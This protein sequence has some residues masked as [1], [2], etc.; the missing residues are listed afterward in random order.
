MAAVLFLASVGPAAARIQANSPALAVRTSNGDSAS[1]AFLALSV[2][3]TGFGAAPSGL[4]L[5]VDGMQSSQR[6]AYDL[7]STDQ[8]IVVWTDVQIVAK[9]PAD[10]TRARATVLGPADRSARLAVRYFTHESY[11][12]AA[13]A[14]P[15]G[16]PTHI[17]VDQTGRVWVNPEFKRNYYYYDPLS[18]AVVPAPYPVPMNPPP[19]QNCLQSCVPTSSPPGGEA[20]VVDDR[21]R[22]WLP[23]SGPAVGTPRDHGRVLMYD[24]ANSQLRVYDLPGDL[25]GFLGITWDARR[26]RVWVSQTDSLAYGSGSTLVS[27]DPERVPFETFSWTPG[28]QVQMVQSTF[29]FA[30]TATC[31]TGGSDGPATCSNAP[32]HACQSVEDCVQADL[33][34]PAGVVD[35]SACY[36]A[37]PVGVFE[38]AHVVVHPDGHVWFTEYAAGLGGAL[39]RLDPSTSA[40][41]IYPL[42]P[43]P[44]SPGGEVPLSLLGYVLIAPWDIQVAADGSIVATEYAANRIARFSFRSMQDTTLCQQLA[45][46]GAGPAACKASYNAR[47]GM[48]ALSNPRCSNPCIQEFT[49]PGTWIADGSHPPMTHL[50]EGRLLTIAFDRARNIWFDQGYLDRKGKFHL[51][52]PLL[53]M[54]PTRYESDDASLPFSGIGGGVAVDLSSGDIWGADYFGRRLNRLHP[55]P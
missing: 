55:V 35:D 18:S 22:I 19:F 9:L 32:T 11:D 44:F 26:R 30:T 3:G 13:A 27:F 4:H 46:P 8:R 45:A 5:H 21:G 54:T 16:P 17:A 31:D 42:P 39:G 49:V 7:A 41:E 23:E 1:G 25:N 15:N 43:A 37:Y 38:P 47:T 12:T 36:H 14:G 10:L 33:F 52:P 29:A 6:V 20:V 51:W 48:V 53:E 2:T 24:P 40:V 28:Q 34:C 50:S